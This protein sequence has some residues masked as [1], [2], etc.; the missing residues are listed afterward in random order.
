MVQGMRGDL[1]GDAGFQTVLGQQIAD[2]PLLEVITVPGQ[3]ELARGCW[4]P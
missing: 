4:R 2:A 1:L 3:E